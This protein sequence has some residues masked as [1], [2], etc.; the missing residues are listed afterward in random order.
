MIYTIVKD[1]NDKGELKML[2]RS[3]I[4]STKVLEYFDI[5]MCYKKNVCVC[6]KKTDAI[7]STSIEM[8][9]SENTVKRARKTMETNES[10]YSM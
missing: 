5:Y 2:I 8:K 7:T 9:V 6:S 1:M 3:G 4:V 10:N